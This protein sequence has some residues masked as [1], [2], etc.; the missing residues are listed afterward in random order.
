MA[1]TLASWNVLCT[2]ADVAEKVERLLA[3]DPDILALQEVPEH[4]LK[5]ICSLP[6]HSAYTTDWSATA[7]K[8]ISAYNV[9]LS[10][11]PIVQEHVIEIPDHHFAI[12]R[13]WRTRLPALVGW[14]NPLTDKHAI[15]VDVQIGDR[16]VRICNVHLELF[17][18]ETR[19]HDLELILKHAPDAAPLSICG[20]FNVLELPHITLLN[21]LAGG[22][23]SDWLLWWRERS[24]REKRF[25]AVSLQNPLRNR[26]THRLSR[27]QLD[28]ILLPK[29][30]HV[31][32]S[33]VLKDTMG[34]DHNP[35]LIE[36]I[37]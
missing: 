11:S 28:H 15:M 6:Y 4:A 32:H 21:W 29:D 26:S 9:I 34:S 2:N 23:L 3:Y 7:R 37:L 30:A 17:T 24:E 25:A 1:V 10:R 5:K 20:D 8:N 27:S 16:I 35:I 36:C 12:P 14:G 13:P 18:P 19:R 22:K 31:I 33:N